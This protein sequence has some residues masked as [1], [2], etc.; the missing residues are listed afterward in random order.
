[1]ISDTCFKLEFGLLQDTSGS[2]QNRG[3]E[4][5]VP[6][7]FHVGT[8]R[9]GT[10]SVAAGTDPAFSQRRKAKE[11]ECICGGTSCQSVLISRL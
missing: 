7:G 2:G 5:R 3:Q 11:Q 10:E 9:V 6:I 8:G 4:P 1:M